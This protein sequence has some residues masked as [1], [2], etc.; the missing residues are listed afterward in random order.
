YDAF[1]RGLTYF[2]RLTKEGN[3]QARQ[4]FEHAVAL[5]PAYAEAYAWLGLAAR[6]EWV[7]QWSKDPRVLEQAFELAKKALSLADTLPWA[8]GLLGWIYEAKQQPEQALAAVERAIALEPSNA[9][10][11]AVQGDILL[12]AGRPEEALRS[13]EKALRLNPHPPA[14]Y[15]HLLGRVY[16]LT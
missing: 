5:D 10:S 13:I 7:R 6:L 15:L 3:A 4:M 16:I 12:S 9:D 11:Y 14:W 8:Y 2:Y 1:L